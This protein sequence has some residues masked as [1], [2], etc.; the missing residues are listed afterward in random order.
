MCCISRKDTIYNISDGIDGSTTS[1]TFN[2]TF[3]DSDLG[4]SGLL[5][6][7]PIS[8][9]ING[10]CN[11]TLDLTHRTSLPCYMHPSQPEVAVY[12]SN[13]LTDGP[14]SAIVLSMYAAA[15]A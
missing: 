5:A 12:A 8:S 10:I 6:V 1:Y 9:C 15:A 11:I 7:L 3:L 2:I 14:P 13:V 4:C